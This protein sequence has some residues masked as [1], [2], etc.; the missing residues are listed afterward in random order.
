MRNQTE[1]PHVH[2]FHFRMLSRVKFKKGIGWKLGRLFQTFDFNNQ[3]VAVF[4]KGFHLLDRR[5]AGFHPDAYFY[6]VFVQIVGVELDVG[7]SSGIGN[8]FLFET[9]VV[10]VENLGRVEHFFLFV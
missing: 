1:S 9:G 6:E 8:Q 5:V 7:C 2:D 3:V 10:N 4:S